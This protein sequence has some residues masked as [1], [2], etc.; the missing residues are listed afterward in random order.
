MKK[1][2][3]VVELVVTFSVTVVIATFLL[4]LILSLNNIYY[5]T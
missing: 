4:Q 2:F 5:L 3:T 1:G